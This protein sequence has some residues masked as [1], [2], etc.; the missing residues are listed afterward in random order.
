[1]IQN[2]TNNPDHC[3]N[4]NEPQ[5]HLQPH[6]TDADNCNAFAILR[7][8]CNFVQTCKNLH[9]I[10]DTWKHFFCNCIVLMYFTCANLIK[11]S[12]CRYCKKNDYDRWT[13]NWATNMRG[14][15]TILLLLLLR[16]T[17]MPPCRKVFSTFLLFLL[18]HVVTDLV[19]L[20]HQQ[21]QHLSFWFFRD[22]FPFTFFASLS[23]SI[24]NKHRGIDYFDIGILPNSTAT[25]RNGVVVSVTHE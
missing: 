21:V 4:F 8:K 9:C 20:F 24:C 14:T 10:A 18:I 16:V 2:P 19:V 25:M 1:M 13:S 12:W 5:L 11:P 3:Q 23:C 6:C 17:V 22:R 15:N 7:V